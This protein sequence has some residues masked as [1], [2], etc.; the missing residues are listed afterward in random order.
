M[1]KK[2]ENLLKTSYAR[3]TTSEEPNEKKWVFSSLHNRAFNYNTI[4]FSKSHPI[5]RRC[6]GR[7]PDFTF[8]H[9]S[10]SF[11][12]AGINNRLLPKTLLQFFS[13]HRIFHYI[14]CL[15]L[16]MGWDFEKNIVL[17]IC[18]MGYR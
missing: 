4:F 9:F 15:N 7:K 18:G 2:I 17:S 13:F 16:R 5:Q 12:S 10:Y 1:M 6:S 3:I 14:K 11:H 8:Q